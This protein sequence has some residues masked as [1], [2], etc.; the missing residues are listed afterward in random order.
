MKLGLV[1]VGMQLREFGVASFESFDEE[2]LSVL[3]RD[4]SSAGNKRRLLISFHGGC[5]LGVDA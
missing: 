4:F 2:Q 1:L 5:G 3:H